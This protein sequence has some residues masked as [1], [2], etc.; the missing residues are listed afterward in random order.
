MRSVPHPG[1]STRRSRGIDSIE[2]LFVAGSMRSSMIVSER[3]L[4]PARLLRW[5]LPST[6]MFTGSCGLRVTVSS[7]LTFL[8]VGASWWLTCVTV[9]CK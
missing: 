7:F 5:S 1:I 2:T 8:T 3:P 9:F 4:S 6:R